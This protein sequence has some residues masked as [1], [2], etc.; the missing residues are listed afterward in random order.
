MGEI[1][2][3]YIFY[4]NYEKAPDHLWSEA[5]LTPVKKDYASSPSAVG[6]SA[7]ASTAGATST[8]RT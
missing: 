8:L 1:F 2:L 7:T 4:P 3:S 6:A 5:S